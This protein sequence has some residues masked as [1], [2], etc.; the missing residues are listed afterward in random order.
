MRSSTKA[1]FALG[2]LL[3]SIGAADA[4]SFSQLLGQAASSFFGGSSSS[5]SSSGGQSGGRL[6]NVLLSSISNNDIVTALKEA[7][8]ISSQNASSK[9]HAINGFFGNNLIKIL[10]PPEA[11]RMEARLR[12]LN[13]GPQVDEAILSMNRAAEDASGQVFPVFVGAIRGMNIHDGINIVR[14]GAGAATEYLKNKTT[15]GLR[16]AFG[17]IIQRSLDKVDATKYWS[18]VFHAY[19]KIPLVTKINTNLT[20]YVNGRALDG[21]FVVIADEENKIRQNPK[22]RVTDLLKKVFGAKQ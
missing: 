9:L 7:L 3:G 20:E 15:T 2:L 11:Q 18:I 14:G 10:M 13:L 21:L 6:S 16:N 19:N 4:Q 12:R 22:A 5:G 1:I 17:P 8:E